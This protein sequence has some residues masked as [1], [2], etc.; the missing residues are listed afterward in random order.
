[1][2]QSLVRIRSGLGALTSHV[3]TRNVSW[4][5]NVGGREIKGPH[6]YAINQPIMQ[7]INS[8]NKYRTWKLC[9]PNV[10]RDVFRFACL[11]D[12]KLEHD[13]WKLSRSGWDY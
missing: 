2:K 9:G 12:I 1:M 4:G 7:S 13:G 8:V 5:T 10:G 11:G 3:T 6:N